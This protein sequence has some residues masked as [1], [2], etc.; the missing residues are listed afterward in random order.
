MKL[1][2]CKNKQITKGKLHFIQINKQ[3]VSKTMTGRIIFTASYT[4]MS[5]YKTFLNYSKKVIILIID[6]NLIK[7]G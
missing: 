6:N 2:N 1:L 5:S 3:V 4:H 7:Y